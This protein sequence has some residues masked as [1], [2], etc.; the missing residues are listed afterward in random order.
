MIKTFRDD[1]L[2]DF[3]FENKDVTR[4]PEIPSSIESALIRKLT[5]IHSATSTKDLMSPP[6]NRFERLQGNLQGKCSIRVNSQYRL[7]FEWD[8]GKAIGVYLD[9][10]KY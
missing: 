8:K 3:F 6:A 10:H 1:W 5:Y 9:P 2:S 7:I 4:I